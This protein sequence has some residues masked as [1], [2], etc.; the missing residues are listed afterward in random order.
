MQ[1]D[2][3]YTENPRISFAGKIFCLAGKFDGHG[4]P[5]LERQVAQRGGSFTP[6]VSE[7]TD[8]L[9]IGSRGTRCCSF[10]CC[11]RVVEKAV[12]LRKQGAALQ[13]IREAD[14]L[15]ALGRNADLE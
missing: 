2:F 11:T 15:N 4:R 7:E 13:F 8:Y 3:V 6:N 9:V 10:A 1:P 14:F 5:A 12:V